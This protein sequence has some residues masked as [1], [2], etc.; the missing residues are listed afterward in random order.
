[1][2][3]CV[4]ELCDKPVLNENDGF[5]CQGNIYTANTKNRRGV[6]GNAFPTPDGE[7]K[8]FA[9]GV[10]EICY[11][12]TCLLQVL[13]FTDV[14]IKQNVVTCKSP[15]WQSALE[16]QYIVEYC[17]GNV[18]GGWKKAQESNDVKLAIAE[19]KR[20][21]SSPDSALLGCKARVV[22]KPASL[23]AEYSSD[24]D[25]GFVEVVGDD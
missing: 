20:L 7:G 22:K 24:D 6:V 25:D 18:P 2:Q 5:I 17:L 23:I 9:D 16:A 3:I 4:C 19:A 21:V 8:I 15:Q 10:A 11:C 13:G 12:T 14:A 1:M